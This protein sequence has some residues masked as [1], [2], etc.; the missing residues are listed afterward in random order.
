VAIPLLSSLFAQT[1]HSSGRRPECHDQNVFLLPVLAVLTLGWPYARATAQPPV[2]P[3]VAR[4]IAKEAYVYGNPM[5]DNYR[6]QYAYFV[7]S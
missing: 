2:T 4:A 1:R 3:T 7:N 6:V 5:V